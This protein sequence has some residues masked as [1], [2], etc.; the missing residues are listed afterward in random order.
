MGGRDR[1][2]RQAW[3]TRCETR[4]EETS[5]MTER[6]VRRTFPSCKRMNRMG[7]QK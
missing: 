6:I 1:A 2:G 3:Q 4:Y 5:R 7:T